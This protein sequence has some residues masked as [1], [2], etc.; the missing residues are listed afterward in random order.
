[1]GWALKIIEPSASMG[2]F[3]ENIMKECCIYLI[4]TPTFKM[5]VNKK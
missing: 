3:A 5:Y 1:M 2:F 4:I